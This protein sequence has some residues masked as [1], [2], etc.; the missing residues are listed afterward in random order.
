MDANA[1]TRALR[2]WSTL[3]DALRSA[4]MAQILM[5]M[6]VEMD[7]LARLSTLKRLYAKYTALRAKREAGLI[8]DGEFDALVRELS[9]HNIGRN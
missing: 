2:N 4:T 9:N 3:N 1:M 8:H 6:R 5:L 7:G